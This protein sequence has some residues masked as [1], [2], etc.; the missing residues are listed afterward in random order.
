M[1]KFFSF[2][3]CLIVCTCFYCGCANIPEIK[4]PPLTYMIK[5]HPDKPISKGGCWA[6]YKTID[7]TGYVLF[8]N[9]T[10]VTPD[11]TKYISELEEGAFTPVLRNCD[12]YIGSQL[13][14]PFLVVIGGHSYVDLAFTNPANG[15]APKAR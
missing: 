5:V 10:R 1:Y 8:L 3:L 2:T 13:D 14:I 12:I 11:I 4:E 6:Q 15:K 7:Q 9:P